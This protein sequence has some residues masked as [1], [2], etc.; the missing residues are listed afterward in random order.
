MRKIPCPFIKGSFVGLPDTWMGEHAARRDQAAEQ[1]REK[2]LG[3]TLTYFAVSMALLED[4]NL[5]GLT[6][7]PE[8]WKYEGINLQLISWVSE[9]VLA[10]FLA[11]T[12]SREIYFSQSGDL[13]ETKESATTM[14]SDPAGDSTQKVQE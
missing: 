1:C 11:R 9:V 8:Q 6:G 13:P 10:D 14:T 7:N 4:W 2:K 3:E 12:Q 5:P